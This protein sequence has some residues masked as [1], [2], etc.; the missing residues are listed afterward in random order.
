MYRLVDEV[1][2]V[3]ANVTQAPEWRGNGRAV[4]LIEALHEV[5]AGKMQSVSPPA[6]LMA[7]LHAQY[8]IA[9]GRGDNHDPRQLLEIIEL[10]GKAEAWATWPPYTMAEVM[11]LE[12]AN[13]PGHRRYLASM[14]ELGDEL[15]QA[16]DEARATQQRVLHLQQ[17]V[18]KA[19]ALINEARAQAAGGTKM[20]E[21]LNAAQAVLQ[22]LA[23]KSLAVSASASK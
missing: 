1:G 3:L 16:N 10:D 15:E 7:R 13:L 2:R 22:D 17:H 21:K 19:N 4:E 5:V 14:R 11:L 20:A 9:L 18:D 6:W 8:A 23:S 12:A